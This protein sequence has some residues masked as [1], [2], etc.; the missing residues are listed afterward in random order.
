MA[1]H[2]EVIPVMMGVRSAVPRR[3]CARET[4]LQIRSTLFLLL[5]F[6]L[7]AI[8]CRGSRVEEAEQTLVL[9]GGNLFDG[10][11]GPVQS[12]S[13]IVVTGEE[14]VCAGNAESCPA[15][16]DA[17]SIELEDG[18]W[19][20]P[21]LVDAHVHFG[22]TGW[23]DGRPSSLDF[24][25]EFPYEQTM[26]RQKSEPERYYRAYLCSGVTAVFD[27]GGYPWSLD[28]R[29]ATEHNPKA[30]HIAAAGPRITHAP[31]E[32]LNLPAEQQYLLLSDEEAG[33]AAVRFMAAFGADAI[34][35]WFLRVREEEEEAIDSRVAAVGE[36]AAARGLP[37]IVHATSLREA[38]VA[39]KAGAHLLVHGVDD[40]LVDEEF[41]SL[42]REKGTIYTPTLLV[43]DGYRRMFEAVKRV[44]Q[45]EL[46]DP[47]RCVD[48]ETRQKILKSP[49]LYNHPSVRAFELDLKTY[50]DRLDA[51]YARKVENLRRVHQAGITIAM[52]TDAGNPGTL[53]GPSIYAELE[54]MQAAGIE[55]AELLVMVTRNGARAMGREDI[56]T[57][58]TGNVADIII[59]S[60]NPLQDVKNLRHITHVMR[61]GKL[62]RIEELA[63]P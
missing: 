57:I 20:L 24:S 12:D 40:Q 56:G 30:P 8:S 49:E 27:T 17:Q 15:P 28:L 16:D 34:K 9:D 4:M 31:P 61:A 44:A 7:S 2:M 43:S 63:R 41:L 18:S 1:E 26:A 21:G 62:H 54:A 13:R 39:L 60:E 10:R 35:V 38:K 52:G 23:F 55:P 50:R 53:H 45:P 32:A 59:V 51:A 29:A 5:V 19:I 42:A 58:A 47:N 33:R 14:I 3:L 25:E 46:D 22:Q 11:G 6:S 48:E 36:E 37:L